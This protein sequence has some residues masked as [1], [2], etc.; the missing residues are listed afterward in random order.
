M[1]K[2]KQREKVAAPAYAEMYLVHGYNA[3]ERKYLI[4]KN[5]LYMS[6]STGEIA[7]SWREILRIAWADLRSYHFLN[8]RW[9]EVS[10]NV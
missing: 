6:L 3:S 7:E 1:P 10:D 8:L 5:K 9:K 4:M 2:I